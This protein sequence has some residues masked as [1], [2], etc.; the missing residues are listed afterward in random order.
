MAEEIYI[1][2]GDEEDDE[3]NKNDAELGEDELE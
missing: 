1:G 2:D 3:K